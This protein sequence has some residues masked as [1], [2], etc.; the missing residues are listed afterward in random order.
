[1]PRANRDSSRRPVSPVSHRGRYLGPPH[2]A[3]AELLREVLINA[4]PSEDV[5]G[6]M[7]DGAQIVWA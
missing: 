4:V 6:K 2:P 3:L 1:M 7:S 5:P